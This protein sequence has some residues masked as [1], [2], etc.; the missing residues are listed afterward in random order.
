MCNF[1]FWDREFKEQHKY[2]ITRANGTGGGV[3]L[4][5]HGVV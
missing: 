2:T 3:L 5:V 4:R 1:D